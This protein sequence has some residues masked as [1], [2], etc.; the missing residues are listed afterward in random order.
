MTTELT[1]GKYRLTE[2]LAYGGMAEVFLARAM[3]A[4][5]FEKSV[6]IKRLHPHFSSDT[7]FVSMLIDEAHL[8][9]QLAH[10]NICQVLDLGEVDGNY[11]IALEYIDGRDLFTI[12][13]ALRRAGRHLPIEAAVYI[14]DEV[15]EGLG[16]AHRKCDEQGRPYNIVHRDISPQNVLATREGEVKIIDFGIAKARLRQTR[17]QTGILKGK[18]RYMAPEQAEGKSVDGRSDLFAA[19]IVLYELLAGQVHGRG[20]SDIQLLERVR[21]A[22]FEPI[23]A[24]RPEV[25]PA[26]EAIV[27]QALERDPARR[28]QTAQDMQDALSGFLHGTGIEFAKR[29]LGAL[30][31][32][33]FPPGT[34]G[35]PLDE[36]AAASGAGAPASSRR[37]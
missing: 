12:M 15:L 30:V 13:R 34:G 36:N 11:Y 5:G 3:G 4:A 10:T 24:L 16:F 35:K 17:T 21:T 25:P 37:R 6:V 19:G 23:R 18:Y 7:E 9:S 1:F 22:T 8:V 27:R 33:L 32:D 2:R 28:F 14:M 20:L 26:L 29:D 31:R